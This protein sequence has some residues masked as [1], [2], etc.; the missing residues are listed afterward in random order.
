M[1]ILQ[2]PE[3]GYF[4]MISNAST[5]LGSYQLLAD[6]DLALAHL[7][8]FHKNPDPY[9]YQIRLVI[10]QR[11]NGPEL[12]ASDWEIFSNAT[13]GQET[14]FWMGDLTFTFQDYALKAGDPYFMRLEISG[15][16][17]ILDDKYICVWSDWNFGDATIVPVGS[18]ASNG[19]RIAL[20][21]K[22]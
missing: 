17:R 18:V 5:E 13:T 3:F 6:G 9:E 10:A 14:G 12:A 21:V 7:R 1:T 19:A 16:T 2:Y 8:V 22:R 4:H 20:G 11:T 15:Y